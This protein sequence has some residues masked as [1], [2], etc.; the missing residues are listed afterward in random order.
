MHLSFY[1]PVD[2]EADLDFSAGQWWYHTGTGDLNVSSI[3]L[4]K[5]IAGI[6]GKISSL[7]MATEQNSCTFKYKRQQGTKFGK[8]LY[9]R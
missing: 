1:S 2:T 7:I 6:P 3:L 5:A 8:S 4:A 9:Q